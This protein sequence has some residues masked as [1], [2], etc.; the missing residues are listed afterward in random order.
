MTAGTE[1]A[2]LALAGRDPVLDRL[3]EFAGPCP[4]GAGRRTHSHF[5]YIA[6]SICYQQLAGNAAKAI[7]GRARAQISGPYRA[8]AVLGLG[9]AR[10]REA[11]LSGAKAR[12]LLDLATRVVSGDIRLASIGRR[13]DDEIVAELCRV[14]GIG[15][16]TAQMFLLF[17]L[18]R[19]DVWPVTDYGVRAGVAR[20]WGWSALPT[21]G[22]LTRFGDQF[23][24][25]RSTVAWYAW[26]AL[27]QERDS[28][29]TSR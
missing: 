21:P 11:G 10:L 2:D 22:E 5:E 17:Q 14:R 8:P 28:L 23:R 9:E 1:V 19:P 16:W 29:P 4:L 6:R 25:F 15:P 7:W 26:R 12:S 20:A 27:E 13:T 3:I 24:P 18:D